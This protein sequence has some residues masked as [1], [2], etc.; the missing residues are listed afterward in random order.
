MTYSPGS[1]LSRF[2]QALDSAGMKH[3]RSGGTINSQCPCHDDHT[4]SMSVEQGEGGV[5]FYCH[6]CGREANDDIRAALGL[7]SADLFDQPLER[8]DQPRVVDTYIYEDA[9]GNEA[10]RR[11]RREP[12]KDGKSKDFMQYR[13][14][15]GEKSWGIKGLPRLLWRLPQLLAAVKEGRPVFYVEGE[16]SVRALEKIGEVATTSGG[17]ND[18]RPEMANCFDG[19]TLVTIIADN[20]DAGLKHA[21]RVGAALRARGTQVR[22]V[23][24]AV[25]R[26][27]A[28]I[29]EHLA[30]G[31][32]LD[33][34]I[35]VPAEE[36]RRLR[37]VPPPTPPPPTDGATARQPEPTKQVAET[38][39]PAA[40]FDLVARFGLPA[41]T[42]T[43]HG[44]RI[45]SGVEVFT[46]RE[47]NPYTRI[48]YAPLVVT[49][50][51]EDVD[52]E[53]SIELAWLDR[54]AVVRRMVPRDVA[55]RGREL[56][57]QLGA[58]GLPA[59]E[60]DARHVERWLAEFET[61]NATKL[62]HET[63]ARHLGWQPDGTF[64]S[65]A[66]TGTRLE[67]R[68][69]EQ[70]VPAQ[71]YGTTGTLA[72][73]KDALAT[74][75]P[76]EVPRIVVAAS[77]A[78]PLLRPLGMPSFTVDISSR[79]TK[80]KTTALQVGCSVWA[81]PSEHAAGISNWRGTAFAIEKRLN[82]VRGIPTF[83]DE[84]MAV[85]DESIIDYVLYQLPM[86]QGK[87]RSGGYAG[88]LPWET[89][90]LSSGE[91]TILSYTRNQ[92]AAGRAL[93]TTEAPF[94]DG[95]G[96]AAVAA[97]ESVFANYGHAGPAF[98]AIIRK[99]LARDGGRERLR[100][101]HQELAEQFR[102]DNDMTGRRAPMVAALA[103][104]EAMACEVGILPYQPLPVSTWATKFTT[105]TSTDN[106]P[107]MAMDVVREYLAAHSHELWSTAH[108]GSTNLP[109]LRGWL[110]AHKTIDNQPHVAV[111]PERLRAI[112]G[113]AGYSLDAVLGSWADAGYL[114]VKQ[115]K[116]KPN[117]RIVTRFD[118]HPARCFLFTPA[119]LVLDQQEAA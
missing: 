12:G 68:Y 16:K 46:G 82:L 93:C 64:V 115:E 91:R 53:Q 42:K 31:H 8:P 76:F 19:A 69:D 74:L 23:R 58:A 29:V 41:G 78:A 89:I 21:R 61:H 109:P 37:S 118:G 100:Q 22:I 40:A 117:F 94:G 119:A 111:L 92:G 75:E 67:V 43:P 113:D 9:D 60:S 26:P 17:A 4:P 102:G 48:T 116:G 80:G 52:G 99:G 57:K 49:S 6:V 35:D 55:K 1:A 106:Q 71:A 28:D 95:G 24:G 107:E 20:D 3:N 15:A 44:Y 77:L 70:R 45:R 90:L 88:A 98:A 62:P 110:G 105:A 2:V 72:A 38:T 97:R 7:T 114:V 101:R 50:T 65:A 87:D 112:L 81:N 108:F 103:L 36:P 73:W 18:W 34:L 56:V 30:A 27:K 47:D 84:T 10:Y 13:L 39:A 79:S 63:L 51:F 66:D 96:P 33:A 32:E 59:I 86:N 25:D 85:S 11:D 104:A 5:V 14:V 54:G 83:L